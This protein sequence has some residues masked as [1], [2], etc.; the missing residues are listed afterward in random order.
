MPA[1]FVPGRPPPQPI[2][3]L[4]KAIIN[5]GLGS[6][7]LFWAGTVT[8]RDA[9]LRTLLATEPALVRAAAP[10]E[11]AR[12]YAI[13]SGI[14][15]VSARA[16]G[17]RNDGRLAA[18]PKEMDLGRITCPTFA[19]SCEDDLFGTA[20]AARHVAASVSGSRLLIFPSG[21]HIWVGRDADLFD[22][23]LDFLA[24]R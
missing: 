12:V 4:A 16:R 3:A 23:V 2:G 17:L 1:T 11:Q 24:G 19:L 22:A 7:F 18:A 8:A 9:M 6:N 13:L 14:L 5:Y 21:G 15:P 20:A 10:A